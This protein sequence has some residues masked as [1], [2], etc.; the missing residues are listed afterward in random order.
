MAEVLFVSKPVEPPWNDSSKNLARDLASAMRHHT[1]V[2]LG[3][4]GA[5]A[6]GPRARNEAL[7]G[8]GATGFAPALSEKAKLFA[9]LARAKEPI[10][11]FFFAP[12]VLT[13]NAGRVVTRTRRIATV[14]TVCSEPRREVDLRTVLFAD[15]NV[16][17]SR[18]TEGRL[19]A[20]GLAAERVRRIAPSVPMLELP[21]PD[22]RRG[23][24]RDFG[25]PR[26]PFLVVYPGD[27]EFGRGAVTILEAVASMRE[28]VVLAMACRTKTQAATEQEARLRSLATT[29]GAADRVFWMGETR[30]IH[31]LLACAD[32][33]AL[34]TDTLYAKM[35]LPLVLLESMALAV[36]TIVSAET[37][38]S[39]LAEGGG[40]LAVRCDVEE[41]A[42]TIRRVA[43]DAALATALGR[44]GRAKVADVHSPEAMAAAYESLYDHLLA[45]R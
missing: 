12:N 30:R 42:S 25:L 22:Q 4:A 14:H 16:V 36:P 8:D 31:Q 27:L 17:L 45:R 35:D 29:L 9:R 44:V 6:V 21:A 41:V 40:A 19:R 37:A 11:H 2:L 39:E 43:T 10:A 3:R 28:D 20:A 15:V 1:P 24:R 18:T 13:S 33:V 7:L 32:L 38:A 5:P 34:P 26:D 23:F